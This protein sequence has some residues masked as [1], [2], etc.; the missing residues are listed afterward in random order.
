[1]Y[2]ALISH[3]RECA[4]LDKSNNTYAEAADAIEKLDR[5]ALTLQHE[6]MAEA[7]SHLA[8]VERLNVQIEDLS[9][10]EASYK[11]SMEEWADVSEAEQP[12]WTPAD[13]KKPSDFVS[14]QAHMTDAGVFPSVREGYVVHGEWFFPALGEFHPVDKWMPFAE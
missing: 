6:M 3:L 8:L 9:M 1:M 14:V 7:E 2:G 13:E 5:R 10:R 4:K 12:K 11:R